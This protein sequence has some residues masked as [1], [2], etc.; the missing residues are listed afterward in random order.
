MFNNDKL[1]VFYDAEFTGLNSDSTLISISFISA[2]TNN[3]FYAEFT[4]YDTNQVN[5]WIQENVINNLCLSDKTKGGYKM[6]DKD[7]PELYCIGIKDTTENI[8][9]ALLEWLQNES[10]NAG[11]QIQIYCDCYAYDWVL[12]NKLICENGNALNIPEYIYYIPVDLSTALQIKNIDPDITRE[13]FIGEDMINK[14]KENK[15]F[16][17]LGDKCKHNSLWDT[18]VCRN[19]FAKL[20]IM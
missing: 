12:F 10:K 19:C 11:A 7:N 18:V 1:K 14:L 8:K 13:E 3:W 15:L 17:T 16:A 5:D 6:I 9:I 20:G 2:E 4:D